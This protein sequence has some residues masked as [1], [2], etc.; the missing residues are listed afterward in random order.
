MLFHVY[1]CLLPK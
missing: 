1:I